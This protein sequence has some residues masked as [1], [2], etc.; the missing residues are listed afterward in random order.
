MIIAEVK[1]TCG[2]ITD[3]FNPIFSAA[4]QDWAMAATKNGPEVRLAGAAE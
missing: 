3:R 1:T 4:S 2:C